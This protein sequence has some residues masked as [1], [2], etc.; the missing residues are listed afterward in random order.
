M[1]KL[2]ATAGLSVIARGTSCCM[3]YC[4]HEEA[5]TMLVVHWHDALDTGSTTC[6]VRTVDTDVVAI[7]IGKF[8]A[9][10]VNNPTPDTWIAFG[11]GNN[12]VS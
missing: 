10:T 5:D 9:L 8:H 6:L 12:F 7:I 1:A 3:E 4:D 2:F 11:T